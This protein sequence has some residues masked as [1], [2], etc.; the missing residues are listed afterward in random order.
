MAKNVQD[1]KY[2]LSEMKV[3]IT[4]PAFVNMSFV[5][6]VDKDG[7]QDNVLTKFLKM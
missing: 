5:I 4:W 2:I 7:I 3:A 1:V 6:S